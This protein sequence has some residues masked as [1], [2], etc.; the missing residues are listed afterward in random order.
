MIWFGAWIFV[1]VLVCDGNVAGMFCDRRGVA[2]TTSNA[3][4]ITKL[5]THFFLLVLAISYSSHKERLVMRIFG[6]V[7]RSPIFHHTVG[8]WSFSQL[9]I[10]I[11]LNK[12][13][14]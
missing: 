5:R 11:T 4:I 12:L 7:S 3:R 6:N 2:I 9:F 8:F 13:R 1:R 14:E 10:F